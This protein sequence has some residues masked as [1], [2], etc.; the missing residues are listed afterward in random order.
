MSLFHFNEPNSME[1]SPH[2]TSLNDFEVSRSGRFLLS[3]LIGGVVMALLC[4]VFAVFMIP[5]I[6]T[7]EVVVSVISSP[8][9]EEV[10]PVMPPPTTHQ[11]RPRPT[12]PVTQASFPRPVMPTAPVLMTSPAL[13]TDFLLRK[14][15]DAIEIIAQFQADEEQRLQEL[16]EEEERQREAAQ[17]AALLA[18]Q[19]AAEEKIQREQ[20]QAERKRQEVARQLVARQ[21]E[22]KRAEERALA[23]REN[24]A[25]NAA[26][27]AAAQAEEAK[28]ANAARAKKIASAPSVTRTTPP[29]YPTSAR[30]GGHQGT[31]QIAAT[32]TATGK[33]SS[34]RVVASSGHRSLDSSAI[35]AV[36]K[37][38]FAPAKNGL[39]QSIAYQMTIPITFRIN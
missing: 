21:A 1:P 11:I 32:I 19:K 7:P 5:G 38:R 12:P 39:G 37:W 34:P 15:E 23:A 18:Q 3:L 25:R 8:P 29:K 33:V 2:H 6:S 17:A 36:K 4:S 20:E 27:Q 30:R 24:E 10:A 13:D 26:A 31:T 16:L 28:Q 14:N 22:A 9:R 35:A